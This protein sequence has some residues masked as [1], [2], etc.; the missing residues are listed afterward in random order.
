MQ[1]VGGATVK[2]PCNPDLSSG[3]SAFWCVCLCASH[4]HWYE[5]RVRRRTIV[6]AAPFALGVFPWDDGRRFSESRRFHGALVP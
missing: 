5:P 6:H 2:V 1:T 4:W 3:D